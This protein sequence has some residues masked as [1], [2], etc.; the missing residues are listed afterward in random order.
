MLQISNIKKSF[1]KNTVNENILFDNLSITIN[2]GDFITLIGSNGAGKSTLLN[3]ISGNTNLDEGSILLN[4]KSIESLPEYKRTKFIGRVFQNPSSGI[5]PSMTVLE[6]LTMANSKNKRFNLSFGVTKKDREL[7]KNIL[8]NHS[9]GLEEKLDVKVGML[10]GGQRQALSLVMATLSKPALL[11]LDEHTAAL[12][13]SMSEK[14]L[15]ITNS[16]IK[17][18]TITTLMVTH[19]LNQAI[20]LGNRLIM[21]HRGKVVI[22]IS[23]EDKKSLTIEKLLG[24]FKNISDIGLLSDRSLFS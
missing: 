7:F 9:L 16:I 15:N 2:D 17:D 22:D 10:S 24:Y 19:D 4:N 11:L 21:L 12:D 20:S 13:P 3:I 18:N 6:N 23:G 8:S 1:N 5:A 14:V